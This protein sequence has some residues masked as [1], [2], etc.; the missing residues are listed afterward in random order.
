M[1]PPESAEHPA[2]DIEQPLPPQQQ[3]DQHHHHHHHHHQHHS[4]HHQHHPH[5]PQHAVAMVKGTEK[6][7][8]VLN[9]VIWAQLGCGLLM[10]TAYVAFPAYNFVLGLWGLVTCTPTSIARNMR[11]VRFY[12]GALGCSVIT[13]IVWMSLWVSRTIF[14]DQFCGINSV[15]IVTCGDAGSTFPGCS[16]NRFALLLL[17]INLFAK[18]ATAAC[19]VRIDD[20]AFKLNGGSKRKSVSAPVD[21]SA[22]MP[23]EARVPPSRS[24]RTIGGADPPVTPPPSTSP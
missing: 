12:L 20:I 1:A 19:V 11:H 2:A 8:A 23:H 18:V 17:I 7:W 3:H 13:D 24:M 6:Y 14:Y 15:S 9:R 21:P 22:V 16:T 5:E 4:R 10:Q